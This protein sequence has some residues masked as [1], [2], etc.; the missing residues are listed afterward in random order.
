MRSSCVTLAVPTSGGQ[1]W[2]RTSTASVTSV[3]WASSQLRVTAPTQG[4]AGVRSRTPKPGPPSRTSIA[5]AL[6]DA[7]AVNRRCTR[8]EPATSPPNLR[9]VRCQKSERKTR[10]E[11]AELT[12]RSVKSWTRTPVLF[13]RCASRIHGETGSASPCR[14]RRYG[15][16]AKSEPDSRSCWITRR[17]AVGAT[18]P[19][20]SGNVKYSP[21]AAAAPSSRV[22]PRPLDRPG[23]RR[24]TRFARLARFA[25]ASKV[26]R[27]PPA[28]TTSSTS[29]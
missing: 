27:P 29:P 16:T 6:A 26:S 23:A 1:R 25:A 20:R 8:D 9:P 2:L 15:K 11:T 28:A 24:T 5:A 3:S 17:Y 18:R 10:L 13:S 7:S 22:P 4:V 14:I 19:S 21:R 12:R